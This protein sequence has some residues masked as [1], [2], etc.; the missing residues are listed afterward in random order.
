MYSSNAQ[1][2]VLNGS[3]SDT[4]NIPLRNANV[5]AIPISQKEQIQFSITNSEGAYKLNL[6]MYHELKIKSQHTFKTS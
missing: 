1:E 2:L 4:L 6:K 5:L 3:I